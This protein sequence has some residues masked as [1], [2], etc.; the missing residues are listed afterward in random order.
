MCAVRKKG[1]RFNWDRGEATFGKC[2]ESRTVQHNTWIEGRAEAKKKKTWLRT[3]SLSAEAQHWSF[4]E[5]IFKQ[6]NGGDAQGELSNA[7]WRLVWAVFIDRNLLDNE[8]GSWQP[9]NDRDLD[10][11]RR[12]WKTARVLTVTSYPW[13]VFNRSTIKVEV[14]IFK[15]QSLNLQT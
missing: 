5:S 7:L 9:Q 3:W 1:Y 10:A 14:W 6:F 8:N 15:L 2:F 4:F 11:W 12:P 13:I